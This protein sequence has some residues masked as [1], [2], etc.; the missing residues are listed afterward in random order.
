M[1]KPRTKAVPPDSADSLL[2]QPQHPDD[3]QPLFEGELSPAGDQP[4][5]LAPPPE[6]DSREFEVSFGES[7]DRTLDLETWDDGKDLNAVFAK[8]VW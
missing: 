8:L 6:I 1:S 7:L 3:P 5:E 4:G 2:P